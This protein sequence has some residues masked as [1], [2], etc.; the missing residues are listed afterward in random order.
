MSSEVKNLEAI[1]R[2]IDQHNNNCN[3]AAVKILMNPFE[4][5]R[6]DWDSI[7]GLP[8][9]ASDSIGTGAFRIVCANE[10]GEGISEEVTEAIGRDVDSGDKVLMPV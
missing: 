7:R 6:L 9:E 10:I 4:V 2:A 3:G 5:D 8:I 1:S